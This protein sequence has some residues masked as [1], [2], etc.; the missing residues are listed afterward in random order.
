V[1]EVATIAPDLK[2]AVPYYGPLRPE[3]ADKLPQINAAVLAFYGALDTR[4]TSQSTDVEARL[5]AA[6]KTVQIKVEEG[7]MHAFFNDTGTAYN[8]TAADDAWVLTLAW[9]RKYLTA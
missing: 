7:A 8:K 5:K 1:W 9:F 6:G 3:L 4:I 2:A